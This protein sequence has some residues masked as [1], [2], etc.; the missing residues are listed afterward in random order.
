[1]R[2]LTL[3]LDALEVD[4]FSTAG[5]LSQWAAAVPDT[6][7]CNSWGFCAAAQPQ[8]QTNVLCCDNVAALTEAYPCKTT[9]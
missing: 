4:S 3:D 2:N 1:M 7:G 8:T 5:D 6:F 9:R